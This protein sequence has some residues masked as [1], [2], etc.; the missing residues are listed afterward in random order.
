MV[1]RNRLLLAGFMAILAA[2]AW[3]PP[4]AVEFLQIGGADFRLHRDSTRHN[5]RRRLHGSLLLWNY[6]WRHCSR[7]NRIWQTRRRR[8]FIPCHFGGRHFYGDERHAPEIQ[9]YNYLFWGMFLFAVANGTLEEV[10]NPLVATLFP[11]NRTH[12]LNILHAS[13]PLGLIL[14]AAAGPSWADLMVGRGNGSSRSIS[15]RQ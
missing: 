4:F 1:N 12:Y 7:Q 9:A 2:G 10:A 5:R 8:V 11:E 13:W 15:F 6:Y 14:G 3:I